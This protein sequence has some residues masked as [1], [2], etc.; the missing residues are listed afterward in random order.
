MMH[1]SM[2]VLMMWLFIWTAALS[3]QRP[4]KHDNT[5]HYLV[6][7]IRVIANPKE[8]DGQ[9]LRICGYLANNG[10]DNSLG[11]YVSEV[12]GRNGVASNSV[13]LDVDE[14]KVGRFIRN[15]ILFSGVYHAPDP[16]GGENGSFDQ[17]LDLELWAASDI[18]ITE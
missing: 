8:F 6:S 1:R 3:P 7:L 13:S 14:R 9:R 10:I 16:R 4:P 2:V 11:I 5:C 12:D 18:R 17:I 15:Y